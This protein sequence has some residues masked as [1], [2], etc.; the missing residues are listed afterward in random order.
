LHFFKPQREENHRGRKR[1]RK[2][3][4]L[5]VVKKWLKIRFALIG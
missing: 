3:I 1:E 2:K 4:Y 5:S